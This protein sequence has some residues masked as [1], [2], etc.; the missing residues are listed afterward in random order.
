MTVKYTTLAV[1]RTPFT[2]DANTN[3]HAN[4]RKKTIPNDMP[5]PLA[6]WMLDDTPRASS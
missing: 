4:N 6:E 5:S 2:T 1:D 3:N